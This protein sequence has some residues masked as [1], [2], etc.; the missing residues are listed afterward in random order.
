MAFNVSQASP[1]RACVVLCQKLQSILRIRQSGLN[2]QN[3]TKSRKCCRFFFTSLLCLEL[4]VN[5]KLLGIISITS[6]METVKIYS[7]VWIYIW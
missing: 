5:Q 1:N 2:S 7:R 3:T 4:I 6:V